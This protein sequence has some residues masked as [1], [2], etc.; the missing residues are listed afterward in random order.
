MFI[1]KFLKK[2]IYVTWIREGKYKYTKI[3]IILVLVI[4]KINYVYPNLFYTI[5]LRRDN[6]A[7]NVD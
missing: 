7:R 2:V 6:V 1:H 4:Q 3:N 5:K